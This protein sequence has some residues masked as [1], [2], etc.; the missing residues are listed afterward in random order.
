MSRESAE[1]TFKVLDMVLA[2]LQHRCEIM[3]ISAENRQRIE[4]SLLSAEGKKRRWKMLKGIAVATIA[5]LVATKLC[6]CLSTLHRIGVP[7]QETNPLA[8]RIMERLGVKTAVWIVFG[9]AS[10]ISV[11]VGAAY[12]TL[13][14]TGQ[15]VFIAAGLPISLI[16]FAVAMHN[17]TGRPNFI[18][19]AVS[20][21]HRRIGRS[22]MM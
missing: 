13:G 3:Q 1:T 16:Q 5:L 22:K 6:D 2:V 14:K 15:L 18:T 12:I 11:F 19:V 9:L 7:A 4:A 21:V 17:W 10:L 8:R 20:T